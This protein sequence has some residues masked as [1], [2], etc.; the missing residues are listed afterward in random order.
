MPTQCWWYARSVRDHAFFSGEE[1]RGMTGL[2]YY[3]QNGQFKELGTNLSCIVL[4]VY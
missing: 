4:G 1:C 3:G 2:G